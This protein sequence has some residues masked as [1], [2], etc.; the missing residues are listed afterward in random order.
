MNQV[1][2]DFYNTLNKMF[3]NK[4]PPNVQSIKIEASVDTPLIITLTYIP[5]N[6]D[7]KISECKFGLIEYND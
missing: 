7:S 5:M 3:D 1:T 2:F 4:F 6:I